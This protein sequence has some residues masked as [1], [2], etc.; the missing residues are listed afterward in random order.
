[1]AVI[2]SASDPL[3]FIGKG[4]FIRMERGRKLAERD[5]S[6]TVRQRGRMPARTDRDNSNARFA[7]SAGRRDSSE[8]ESGSTARV[9]VRDTS[10][11]M[12]TERM[13]H[14]IANAPAASERVLG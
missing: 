7:S 5:D 2:S 14:A 9:S 12:P 4:R 10:C 11:R 3:P 1:M 6:R 8:S 13:D